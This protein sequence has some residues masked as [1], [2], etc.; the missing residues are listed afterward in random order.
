MMSNKKLARSRLRTGVWSFILFMQRAQSYGRIE[1]AVQ[2]EEEPPYGM[3]RFTLHQ[4]CTCGVSFGAS[5]GYSIIG[6]LENSETTSVK[7]GDRSGSFSI[8]S[9][10]VPPSSGSCQLN[11]RPVIG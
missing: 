9:S 10:N 2:R 5:F 8:M 3:M 4:Y 11:V 1:N 7:T 6:S